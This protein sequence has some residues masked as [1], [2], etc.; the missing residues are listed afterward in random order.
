MEPSAREVLLPRCNDHAVTAEGPEE[1]GRKESFTSHVTPFEDPVPAAWMKF[2]SSVVIMEEC[3][4]Y[5]PV[6]Y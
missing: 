3:N 2:W 4:V 5:I 1:Q 6:S